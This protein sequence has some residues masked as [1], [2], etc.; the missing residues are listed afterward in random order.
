MGTPKPTFA[1][2][3]GDKIFD[4]VK[5]ALYG[6]CDCTEGGCTHDRVRELCFA[7]LASEDR[8]R[9]VCFSSQDR[10]DVRALYRW[11]SGDVDGDIDDPAWAP[12]IRAL[13]LLQRIAPEARS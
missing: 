11:C 7:S 4:E 10:L 13:A 5:T 9:N 6:Q 1:R 12:I 3:H 8:Y 2:E